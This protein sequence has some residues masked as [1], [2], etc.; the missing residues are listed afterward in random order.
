MT[1]SPQKDPLYPENEV[2]SDDDERIVRAL[3]NICEDIENGQPL[4]RKRILEQ[5][6]DITDELTKCLD[7][8]DVIHGAASNHD[9]SQ[10]RHHAAQL[11]MPKL[12]P[13][14]RQ[15]R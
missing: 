11:S 7:G 13:E 3:E 5:Y 2:L 15:L 14:Y 4:D 6:P 1:N 12:Y 8:L 9:A 10:S